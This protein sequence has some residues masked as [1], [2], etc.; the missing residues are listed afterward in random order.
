MKQL[1]EYTPAE[2]EELIGRMKAYVDAHPNASPEQTLAEF[3]I[4]FDADLWNAQIT[5]LEHEKGGRFMTRAQQA[6]PDWFKPRR[7]RPR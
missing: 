2:L 6:E 3:G 5:D 4:P 1:G 7:R